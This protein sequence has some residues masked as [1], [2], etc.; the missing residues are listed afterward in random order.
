MPSDLLRR[1]PDIRAAERRLAAANAQI[2]VQTAV[3]Y[4]RVNLVGLGTFGSNEIEN[5][6]DGRNATSLALGLLQWSV[7]NGGQNQANIRI[8]R[9]QYL[10]S[11]VQYRRSVLTALRE[12]E[13]ALARYASDQRRQQA[14]AGAAKAAGESVR[15]STQQYEV[16]GSTTPPSTTP[17]SASSRCR[18]SWSRPTAPWGPTSVALYKALGGGW[19]VDPAVDGRTGA[20]YPRDR[21]QAKPAG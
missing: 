11:Q 15:I 7:F 4:P 20:D 14:L 3:L 1:R 12:V 8:A 6:F 5:L 19:T 21:G 13:D 16:G 2:G 10:Q 17:R 18:T 9:E